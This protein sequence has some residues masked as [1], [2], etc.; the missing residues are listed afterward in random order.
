MSIKN[1]LI[2]TKIEALKDVLEDFTEEIQTK[3]EILEGLKD[4]N[5]NK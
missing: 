3:I 1:I 5:S 4:D 2:D